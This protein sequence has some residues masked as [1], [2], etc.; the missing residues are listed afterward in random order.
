MDGGAYL[1]EARSGVH[2][3]WEVLIHGDRLHAES[4][5]GWRVENGEAGNGEGGKM[6]RDCWSLK[7]RSGGLIN[8]HGKQ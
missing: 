3:G 2:W 4:N 1:S 6:G 7:L 5:G 8:Y